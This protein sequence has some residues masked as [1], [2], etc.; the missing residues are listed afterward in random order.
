MFGIDR[1]NLSLEAAA[2]DVVEDNATD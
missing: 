1:P 2:H